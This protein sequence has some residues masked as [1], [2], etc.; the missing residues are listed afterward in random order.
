MPKKILFAL[1]MGIVLCATTWAQNAT[2]IITQG[3]LPYKNSTWFYSGLGVDLDRAQVKENWAEGRRITAMAYT[4]HGWF[5]SMAENTGIGEQSYNAVWDEDWIEDHW[6][7]GHYITSISYGNESCYVVMSEGVNYKSQS[8]N[9][10]DWDEMEHWI[11][12]QWDKGRYI[13]SAAYDGKQW[14][15]VMSET[16][17]ITY[18]GYLW[19][20]SYNELIKKLQDTVWSRGLRLVLME[21]G[22][23][24]YLAVFA[25][26]RYNSTRPECLIDNPSDVK[27]YL[28]E[29]WSR[30]RDISYIGGGYFGNKLLRWVKGIFSN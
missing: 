14:T 6:N 18:Q 10:S 15:L 1:L 26:Y 20:S 23:G 4:A 24:E 3:G 28:D 30:Q 9:R 8:Y 7:K 19:A 25:G 17:D 2:I 27:A 22:H 11:R 13:T 12:Q 21:F 5:V 16:K 29:E